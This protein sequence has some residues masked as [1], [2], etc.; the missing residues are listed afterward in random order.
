MLLP[1]APAAAVALALTFTRRPTTYSPA[2]IV[3]VPAEPELRPIE[4]TNIPVQPFWHSVKLAEDEPVPHAHA[5]D[6]LNTLT[7]FVLAEI[8]NSPT[9]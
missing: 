1:P 4:W 2:D 3:E 8:E 9:D 5:L 6:A 7:N